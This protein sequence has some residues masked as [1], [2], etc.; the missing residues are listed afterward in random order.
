[1]KGKREGV[2]WKT[3]NNWS[4]VF[5]RAFKGEKRGGWKFFLE[6]FWLFIAFVMLKVRFSNHRLIETSMKYVY[7]KSEVKKNMIQQQ[8]TV[9]NE[10]CIRWLNENCY[11]V[12]ENFLVLEI[13]CC[14]VGFSHHLQ[15]FPERFGW[16]G[17]AVHTC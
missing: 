11:L 12:R 13:F 9:L 6:E 10:A 14:L 5:P 3:N 4:R 7:V 17:R 1:M 16:K 2:K 15:G 8:G